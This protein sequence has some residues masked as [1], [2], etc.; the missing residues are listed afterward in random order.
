MN[1]E[2]RN[3][4][5]V[6]S[7]SSTIESQKAELQKMRQDP[8]LASLEPTLARLDGISDKEF[9]NLFPRI[10]SIVQVYQGQ[11]QAT[12]RKA[13]GERTELLSQS[14]SSLDLSLA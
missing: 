9:Q 11:V 2:Q 6:L 10:Q 8:K 4:N 7:G 14:D 12:Q 3:R 1:F 5:E 13:Q